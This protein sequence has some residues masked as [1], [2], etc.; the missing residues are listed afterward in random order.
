VVLSS[1]IFDIK[2]P[3]KSPNTKMSSY[4]TLRQA[5]VAAVLALG[6][7]LLLD[8]SHIS[9]AS[10]FALQTDFENPT[11]QSGEQ[12]EGDEQEYSGQYIEDEYS[13]KFNE[14]LQKIHGENQ[15][16]NQSLMSTDIES[17]MNDGN[18]MNH[19]NNNNSN[20]KQVLTPQQYQQQYMQLLQDEFAKKLE[21]YPASERKPAEQKLNTNQRQQAIMIPQKQP[22]EQPQK[23]DIM[24]GMKE[25]FG[26]FW[27]KMTAENKAGK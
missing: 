4:S 9:G 6:S 20:N 1:S 17:E 3:I 12:E 22:V 26:Q 14:F 7:V 10:G 18:N 5:S 21:G 24:Q 19:G 15:G 2:S 25:K 13:D 23:S 27:A 16:D 8:V 11:P